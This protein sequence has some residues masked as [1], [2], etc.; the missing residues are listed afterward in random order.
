MQRLPRSAREIAVSP[1]TVFALV[2][3]MALAV[4]F[5]V[6]FATYT[7]NRLVEES[8]QKWCAT[9]IISDDFQRTAPP[10]DDSEARQQA[11]RKYAEEIRH[12]RADFHCDRVQRRR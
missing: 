2:V 3:S 10:S 8:Q 6:W 12:L 5:N 9:I 4:L 7:A 11:L 1:Y